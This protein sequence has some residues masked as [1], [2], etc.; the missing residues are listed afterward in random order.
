MSKRPYVALAEV[1]CRVAPLLQANSP[2][3]EI[4]SGTLPVILEQG[5][6]YTY[7]PGF[8]SIFPRT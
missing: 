6:S 1:G 5:L 2:P 7:I 4:S 3:F 8:D